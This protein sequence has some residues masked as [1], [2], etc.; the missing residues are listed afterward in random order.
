MNKQDLPAILAQVHFFRGLSQS[1]RQALAEVARPRAVSRGEILFR[2]RETGHSVYL[3]NR[4]RVELFKTLPGG[5]EV[6]ISVMRPGQIFAEIVLFEQDRYPVTARALT[7]GHLYLFPRQEIRR[8]LG[9]AT[10]R[11]DFL[12]MMFAK[13][14][15]LTERILQS[16]GH[17]VEA[18]FFLFLREQYGE[19]KEIRT[20]LSKRAVAAAIRTTPESLSRLLKRL[21]AE[22]RATWKGSTIV[23]G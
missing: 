2:E 18:R 23:L 16:S 11:N 13:Q 8:L 5:E 6:V 7:A 22:K 3:V 15:H 10:F 19:A 14:R 1:S 17:D 20:D 9:E 12:S 4:G 21:T